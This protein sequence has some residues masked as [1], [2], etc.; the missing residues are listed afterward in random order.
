MAALY[1]SIY[2]DLFPKVKLKK[3][4]SGE[5]CMR[6]LKGCGLS[7]TPGSTGCSPYSP[8]SDHVCDPHC[9][10]WKI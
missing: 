10:F 8:G 9:L 2:L 7:L 1:F 6:R 5:D 3:V 4:F